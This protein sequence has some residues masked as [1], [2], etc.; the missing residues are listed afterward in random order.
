M[1]SLEQI[2]VGYDGS[3]AGR[4]ALA[5]AE[6]LA[7]TAGSKLLIA[8]VEGNLAE[9]ERARVEAELARDIEAAL[10]ESPLSPAVRLLSGRS[11]ARALHELTASDPAIGLLVLG[12]THREG[13]GRV[14]PGGVAERLL[15]GASLPV[16]VAP[17][18]YAEGA[19]A[20]APD[21][22]VALADELRVVAV[23][24]DASAEARGALE[25]AAT[26]ARLAEATVRVIAVGEAA[27]P[28]GEAAG[29][30][31]SD[32]GGWAADLQSELHDVVAGLPRELRAL[33]IYERGGAARRLLARA[34]EGV[35]LLVMG[36]RGYGP[37][38]AVLLGSTSA[39]VIA[40]APCPVI[41]CP[42]PAWP[43]AT[44]APS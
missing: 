11:P 42:R 24:F 14:V 40:E 7:R 10:A 3:A 22:A 34:E 13:L 37:L 29:S 2:V 44:P 27:A 21:G 12:S 16:A 9:P 5:L 23:A 6:R 36:S 38:R 33:P 25:L 17:R 28:A 43:P 20:S 31:T 26:I 39:V 41:V 30:G 32:V 18:G 15:S 1:T 35:D 8:R 4:D 19:A